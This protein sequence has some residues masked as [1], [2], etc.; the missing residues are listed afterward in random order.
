MDLVDKTSQTFIISFFFFFFKNNTSFARQCR[1]CSHN[2]ASL[3]K[4]E[5]GA[6]LPKPIKYEWAL[7]SLYTTTIQY[8]AHDDLCQ[9][10]SFPCISHREPWR[11]IRALFSRRG[12]MAG[13]LKSCVL[14]EA[15]LQIKACLSKPFRNHFWALACVLSIKSRPLVRTSTGAVYFYMFL[16]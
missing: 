8:L 2:P 4:P 15:V 1:G 9:E 13:T 10:Y 3:S 16:C 11:A 6:V 12:E 5:C 14:E 7:I